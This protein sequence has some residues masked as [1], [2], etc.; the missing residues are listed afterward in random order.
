MRKGERIIGNIM[1][2]RPK[3]GRRRRIE[4][5]K[6]VREDGRKR[7]KVTEYLKKRKTDYKFSL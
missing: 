2:E 5:K 1:L 3:K 6:A 4:E 7:E